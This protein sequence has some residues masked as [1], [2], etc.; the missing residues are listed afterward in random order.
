M[1]PGGLWVRFAAPKISSEFVTRHVGFCCSFYTTCLPC[2]H[3][4]SLSAITLAGTEGP[5]VIGPS[6]C[7]NPRPTSPR[8]KKISSRCR[9]T[10]AQF[11]PWRA[12]RVQLIARSEGASSLSVDG[13]SHVAR[14]PSVRDVRGLLAMEAVEVDAVPEARDT[15]HAACTERVAQRGE[16]SVID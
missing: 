12:P 10:R 7:Q 9:S 5:T 1:I 2:C 13:L 6:P 16:A 8:T 3:Y 4:L 15:S 14:F 11:L